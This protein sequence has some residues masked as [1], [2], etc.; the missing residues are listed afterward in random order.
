MLKNI[1]YREFYANIITLRFLLGLIIC[2]LLVAANTYVLTQ[3]YENRLDSYQLAVKAH[4]DE[5]R[6]IET[7]SQL[8]T[9]HTPKA[10]K[11]P[12]FMSILNEGLET[13]LGNTVEVAHGKVP[14]KATQH[15]ADNPYLVVFR[16]IDL[17][18]VFQIVISLLALLFS[19][20]TISGSR[21]N[22]TLP[23][24]LS[25]P[26]PRSTLLF[27]KYLGG[28]LSLALALVISLIVG[29]LI[30]LFSSYAEVGGSE[31]GRL[32]LFLII[33]LIYVSFF[34]TMGMLISSR[35]QRTATSL[36]L[37]MF[38]W[39]FMVLV[40]PNS[41]AFAVSKLVTIESDADLSR[42]GFEALMVQEGWE[43]AM[44]HHAVV[45]LWYNGYRKEVEDFRNK[46][47]VNA[48][49]T[50][51]MWR[52]FDGESLS[53]K[54]NGSDEDKSL[55]HEFN[56]FKEELR[57]D[58]ADRVGKMWQE[59]LENNPIRQARLV[60]NVSL[61]S[62]ASMF[63]KATEI[64]AGTDLNSHLRFLEQARQYRRDIIQYLR[65]QDAFSSPEWYEKEAGK[66]IVGESIPIFEERP[67]SLSSSL[68]RA[69]TYILMLLFLNVVLFLLT[70]AL[71]MRYKVK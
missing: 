8:A 11:K 24:T 16:R 57:I 21:E 41:S 66:K 3:N 20:D 52:D 42:E 22:G 61:V 59:Y 13:R 56:K 48:A 38:F 55:Y 29:F 58:Y 18:L 30:M 14:V 4:T 17:T 32:I 50:G 51:S 40:Y 49:F 68:K 53:G 25:N 63:A 33:S 44:S 62:P 60:E 10:D 27:G 71:F 6:N 64:I 1:I 35:T 69:A 67:E 39:V 5:I 47:K 7:Y 54:Y 43:S 12:R 31:R 37:A 34:F 65:D 15:G 36:I 9:Q 19:Y 46:H 70:Y 28:M 45:D 26:V 23:L 2:I